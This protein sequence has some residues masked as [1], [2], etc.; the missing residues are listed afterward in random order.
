MKLVT[1]VLVVAALLL[2]RWGF[3]KRVPTLRN[4]G[5]K[6]PAPQASTGA[7]NA[8]AAATTETTGR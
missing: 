7:A 1:A 3:L 5:G 4:R 8:A 6:A 2:P